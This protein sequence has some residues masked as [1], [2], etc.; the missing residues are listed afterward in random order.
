MSAFQEVETEILEAV[1]Q[2]LHELGLTY[3]ILFTGVPRD[4]GN[5]GPRHVLS[6]GMGGI[7]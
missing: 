1:L 4:Q 2:R 5:I 3:E 6:F 7:C